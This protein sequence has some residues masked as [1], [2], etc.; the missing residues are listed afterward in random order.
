[1]ML[2]ME[3]L[4]TDIFRTARGFVDGSVTFLDRYHFREVWAKGKQ[5]P[6]SPHSAEI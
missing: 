1:L 6:V 3:L 4:E 5:F 2:E